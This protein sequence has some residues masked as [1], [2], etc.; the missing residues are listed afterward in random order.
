MKISIFFF[1]P[2]LALHAASNVTPLD[3]IVPSGK[4]PVSDA[5]FARRVYLDVWGLLPTPEQLT[6]FTQSKVANKNERLVDLLLANRTN[7]AEHWMSFW[8][9][10]L[11]N[12]EGVVYH[13][14]R[15]Y[16]TKWLRAALEKNMPYDQFVRALISPTAKDDPEGFIIGVNWRGTVND[17][18]LPPMQAAQNTAQIFLGV[19][20]KCNSCHDSFISKWKLKDAYGMASFFSEKPLD[21]VRCDVHT[22]ELS[23]PKYLFTGEQLVSPS[24]PLADRRAALAKM[25][26]EK[27]QDRLARTYVNRIW[28]RL[29]GHGIVEPV[30]NLDAKAW[31]PELL[32]SLATDFKASGFNAQALLKRILTSRAYQL[33]AVEPTEKFLFEG[34]LARRLTAEQFSDNVAALTGEW[35]LKQS[36]KSAEYVR[37]WQVKSTALTRALGRPIRDQVTTDRQDAATMLQALELVNGTVLAEQLHLGAQRMLGVRQPPAQNIFDS[38]TIGA[39]KLIPVEFD[40]TGVDKLW[41]LMED[42]ESYDRTRVQ[43]RWGDLV[44]SGPN[45]EQKIEDAYAPLPSE[46]VLDL[47]GKGYTKLKAVLGFDEASKASDVN[48][49]VRFFAFKSEPDRSQLVKVAGKLPMEQAVGQSWSALDSGKLIDR[50]YQYALSRKP[51]SRE[52]SVAKGIAA[53]DGQPSADGLEDLLWSL[54]ISPEFQFIR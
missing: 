41:L 44:L 12:D 13:G 54:F 27:D 50:V 29:F 23:S 35:R 48:A 37:E 42:F 25:I 47:R 28:K 9:D 31:N 36:G 21:V 24:A 40:I 5:V 2:L 38:G 18:E 14:D 32:A 19:N 52:A 51:N 3:S 11:R 34:P 26:T 30:D 8:N 33:P 46:K 20:L 4:A 1:I 22:G 53:K 6:E 17:S 45:G 43:G 16:I 39:S 15:K 7:Y 10:H 49:H